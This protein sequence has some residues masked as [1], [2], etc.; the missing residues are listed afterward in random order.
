MCSVFS[1]HRSGYYAWLKK[2]PGPQKRANA[3]LDEKLVECYSFHKRRYGAPRLT[4]DLREKGLSCSKNRV[5]RRMRFLGIS[6][7][8]KRKF[9]AM[10][11]SPHDLPVAPN[12]LNRDFTATAPNQKYAGDIT[13]IATE[14]GWLYL[15]VVMDL[16]SRAIIGWSMQPTM[17]QQLVGDALL[18][19]LSKRKLPKNVIFHS[20]RG[21]QYCAHN[22]QSLLSKYQ[23]ISSMSRKGNCWDN[24]VVE[25]FF[26]TLKVELVYTER[27]E[28]RAE[29][30]A[31]IF[32]YVETYYNSVRRHSYTQYLAPLQ[33]E[34]LLKRIG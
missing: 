18:M 25:S 4:M 2:E 1:V 31:S 28:T 7:H 24:S 11:Y 33:F 26:H 14:E 6:A 30:K 32:N 22:F 34:G 3:E 29:A 5:A 15:A 12:R 16:Y 21:S 13:Y 8:S 20:D 9:K 10:R 19:A 27:Y 23:C 17:T